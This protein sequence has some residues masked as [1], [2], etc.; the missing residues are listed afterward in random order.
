MLNLPP[1]V[2]LR[3]AK[4]SVRGFAEYLSASVHEEN[5]AAADQSCVG[6]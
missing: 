4:G 3:K 1:S 2:Q 6:L 5:R